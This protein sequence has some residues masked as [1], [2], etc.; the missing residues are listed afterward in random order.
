MDFIPGMQEFFN[1]HK[2]INVIYHI[3]KLKNKNHAIISIDAEKAFDCVDH[4]KLWKSLKEMGITDH[5]T[6]IQVRKQQ[7]ELDMQQ[8]TGS[9]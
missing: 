9:K 5:L 1:I 3:N 4:N 2:W 6:N 8:Q 7:L